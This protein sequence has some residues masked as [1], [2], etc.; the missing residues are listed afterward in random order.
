[1]FCH[2]V[3][4]GVRYCGNV[5]AMLYQYFGNICCFSFANISPSPHRLFLC[6]ETAPNVKDVKEIILD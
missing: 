1:M 2:V 4:C 6:P 3:W 5:V